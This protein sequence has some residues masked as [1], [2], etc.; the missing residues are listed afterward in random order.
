[1]GHDG[2]RRHVE[3]G[4]RGD[5]VQVVEAAE[6]LRKAVREA[7]FPFKPAEKAKPA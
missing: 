4:V 2:S 1:M 3:L 5:P 6:S 7:G